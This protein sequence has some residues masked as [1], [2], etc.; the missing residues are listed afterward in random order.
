MTTTKLFLVLVFTDW[1]PNWRDE[2]LLMDEESG[3]FDVAG[4][5]IAPFPYKRERHLFFE[6]KQPLSAEQIAL[7]EEDKGT[8]MFKEFFV[9]QEVTADDGT[10]QRTVIEI[11]ALKEYWLMR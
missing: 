1:N 6:L 10:V 7:L 11:P 4:A 9:C 3:V 5:G 2:F 8:G